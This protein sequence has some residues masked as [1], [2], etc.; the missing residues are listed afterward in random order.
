MKEE[1]AKLEHYN[2]TNKKKIEST[3]EVLNNAKKLFDIRSK[4]IKSFEDG[5]FLL[6][7]ANLHKEQAEEK[8][9]KRKKK[10]EFLVG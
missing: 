2:P 5:T 7:R 4:I 9:R 8:K 6:S 10:K 3:E 1:I